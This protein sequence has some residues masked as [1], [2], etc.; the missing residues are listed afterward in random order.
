[1][2]WQ[3][4]K[5]KFD[6]WMPGIFLEQSISHKIRRALRNLFFVIAIIGIALTWMSV[7]YLFIL[8]SVTVVMVDAFYYSYFFKEDASEEVLG[9][10]L[11]MIVSGT[12]RNDITGGFISSGYGRQ[13]L[14]RLGIEDGAI[15]DFLKNRSQKLATDSLTFPAKDSLVDSYLSGLF[16]KDEE[17]A[18]FLMSF[19]VT[20]K[21]F[22]RS[23]KWL[24]SSIRRQI[25]KE[26]WWSE[27]NLS[28]TGGIGRDWSY[29]K[30]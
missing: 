8:L 18:R 1:M 28:A 6:P 17:F 26:R 12:A 11:A 5:Q 16:L 4:L 21:I 23:A 20:E 7:F 25:D 27:S 10:E 19:G 30:T 15:K 24:L 29:G 9:F 3:E 22:V 14:L 13:A 2:N